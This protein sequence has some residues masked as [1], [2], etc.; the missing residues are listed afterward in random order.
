[1]P[2]KDYVN[3]H[4]DSPPKPYLSGARKWLVG[5]AEGGVMEGSKVSKAIKTSFQNYLKGVRAGGK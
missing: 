3:K 4:K 1:M 5:A 2:K